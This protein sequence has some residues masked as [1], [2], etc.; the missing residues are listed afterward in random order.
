[1]LGFQ[2]IISCR[3]LLGFTSLPSYAFINLNNSSVAFLE[4]FRPAQ[5]LHCIAFKQ[6]WLCI[7]AEEGYHELSV[8]NC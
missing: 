1:M 4:K 8:D 2:T 5:S 6:Q 7:A 3:C